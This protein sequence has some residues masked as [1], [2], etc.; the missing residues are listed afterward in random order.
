MRFFLCFLLGDV[1]AEACDQLTD[2]YQRIDDEPVFEYSVLTT[3]T[4]S[5]VTYQMIHGTTV[6]FVI[7]YYKGVQVG[8]VDY[9]RCS[10]APSSNV[11]KGILHIKLDTLKS[12]DKGSYY[13]TQRVTHLNCTYLFIIGK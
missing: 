1:L 10:L 2:V 6:L 12:G 5:L 8:D 13:L 11:S 3:T 7:T 4:D 9:N